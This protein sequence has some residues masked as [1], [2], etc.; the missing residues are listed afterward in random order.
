MIGVEDGSS[1]NASIGG[2]ENARD[3]LIGVL[4]AVG[5]NAT[6]SA[7]FGLGVVL[8]KVDCAR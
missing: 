5:N 3:G 2:A 7:R 6:E 4:G 8:E 1:R